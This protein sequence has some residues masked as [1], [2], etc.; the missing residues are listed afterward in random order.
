MTSKLTKYKNK[1][2]GMNPGT[3]VQ[4]IKISIHL[5]KT[6]KNNTAFG[7]GSQLVFSILEHIH[8]IEMNSLVLLLD[9]SHQ[10]L[11]D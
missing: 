9:P 3:L 6:T 11:R 7:W 4:F 5:D 1:V 8:L 10:T 2:V